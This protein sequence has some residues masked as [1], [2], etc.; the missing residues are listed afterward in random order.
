MYYNNGNR[1]IFDFFDNAPIG[2]N[3][4][5]KNNGE[6]EIINYQLDSI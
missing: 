6:I 5:F 4:L 1:Q 2:N 3:V